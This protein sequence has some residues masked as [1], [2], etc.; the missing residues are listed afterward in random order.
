MR[1]TKM[2]KPAILAFALLWHCAAYADDPLCPPK[3]YFCWQAKLVFKK[4]GVPRVVAQAKACGWSK[5]EIAEALACR[6]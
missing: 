2:L 3:Y 6:K 5:E 4:Y 1:L